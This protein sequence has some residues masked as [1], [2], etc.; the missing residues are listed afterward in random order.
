MGRMIPETAGRCQT[1]G[2]S[3]LRATSSMSTHSPPG[4]A[5]ERARPAAKSICGKPNSGFGCA[6]ARSWS[7][8][9]PDRIG[10]RP[11]RRHRRLPGGNPAPTAATPPAATVEEHI[12]IVKSPDGGHVLRTPQ[13]RT[14]TR[15]SRSA[16]SWPR[17]DGLHHRGH[18]G[19]QRDSGGDR[20]ARSS[21]CWSDDERARSSSATRCSRST[22]V[23]ARSRR[24]TNES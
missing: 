16:T 1:S 17:N 8:A 22:P 3:R 19:L 7:Y 13:S 2:P 4:R 5:D 24:C 18:E 6:A 12:V 14:R 10:R 11:A 21:R 23:P 15:T 20:A 9:S